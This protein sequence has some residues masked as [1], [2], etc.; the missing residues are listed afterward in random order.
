[1]CP[2]NE[3]NE[4]KINTTVYRLVIKIW[5]NKFVNIKLLFSCG[6]TGGWNIVCTHRSLWWQA[7]AIKLLSHSFSNLFL[8][9]NIVMNTRF[10][11][12]IFNLYRFLL[13]FFL[14]RNLDFFLQQK[15]F[16]CH[17]WDEKVF[18]MFFEKKLFD[19]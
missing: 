5:G 10:L 8:P 7:Q 1:M 18:F 17:Y 6:F 14:T 2:D 13:I 15:C 9:N 4:R 3:P 16:E 19:L 11:C 12:K